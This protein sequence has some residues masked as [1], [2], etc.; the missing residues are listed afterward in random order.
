MYIYVHT[1][2]YLKN[3]LLLDFIC[4]YVVEDFCTYIHVRPSFVLCYLCLVLVSRKYWSQKMSW[5]SVSSSSVWCTRLFKSSTI[6]WN[7]C[8]QEISLSETLNNGLNFCKCYW[9]VQIIYFIW[10]SLS[11]WFS[12]NCSISSKFVNFVT[13]VCK[14]L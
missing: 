10:L 9:A 7:H 8:N 6:W 14:P 13:K 12:R 5:G 1:Y 3:T 11:S 2:I 4:T